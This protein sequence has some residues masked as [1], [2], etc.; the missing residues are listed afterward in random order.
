MGSKKAE[1][2]WKREEGRGLMAEGRRLMWLC[3][4]LF[5]ISCSL[6][7]SCVQQDDTVI[8]KDSRR[9]VEKTVA[10]VAPLNDPI[11]KTRLERTAGWM[12]NNL[13]NAQLHD[14]LCIDLKLEWYD[15]YGN[16]LKELGERLANRNDLM[17]VIGPF[18]SDNV[19]Q[20]APSCQRTHKPLI[21]PTATS[22]TV[23]RRFAITSSGNGQQPF[24]WSLT[25]TDISLSEILVSLY[26]NRLSMQGGTMFEGESDGALFAPADNYG[27]TFVEW[28]PFLTAELGF[29]LSLCEQYENNETLYQKI[30]QYL[31]SLPLLSLEMPQFVVARDIEQIYQIARIR[32]ELWDMD[33]DDPAQDKRDGALVRVFWAPVFYACSNITDEAIAALGPRCQALTSG[34][35]GFSPY[36]DP[37]TGFEISYE[38]RFGTKPT[39][40]ECKFY[41]ALLL[42]GFA[43]NYMEH[44]PKSQTP[45][46][47]SQFNDA[48][49]K[50]CTTDNIL[51]GHAWNETGMEL[52]LAALERGEL[53]GFK[54][55]SGP[56]QFDSECYTAALNTTYVNWS[57]ADGRLYHQSY[58][59]TQGNAQTSK[60]LA[61]WNYLMKDAE[62]RFDTDY[63]K[64]IVTIPYPEL[65]DQYAV[66][67][68]GS[69][70]WDNY[71][72]EA[73][74]LNIYQMLKGNGYDDDH[75]ILITADDCANAP[76]NTDKGAV[77]TDPGGK[78]LHEGAVIDYRNTDLMPQDICN[79]LRGNKTDR[80]PIVLPSDAGQNILFFWSGHGRSKAI[81]GV[82]EMAWRDLSSGKGMTDNLLRETLRSMADNKQFRQV[83]VC[84]EPCYSANMGEALKGMQGV[85]A[86][87]AAGAY[88]QSFA[89][90][91]SNEL[92]VW[93]CDRFS[94]NLVSCA[95]ENPD[96]TYRDL[97]LHCAQHT[98]GSHVGIY[99]YENFGNL[100]TM[101][102]KE[103]FVKKK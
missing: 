89:D 62:K 24:L 71:R 102:P 76:E 12:L 75:I 80:T 98:L 64:S 23:I 2:R 5:A 16:D 45:N 33:P 95:K 1:G 10:V 13:H 100:Y 63:S 11:M 14:T 34:Y 84:L 35:Q 66:L 15:E 56:V 32:S 51:S 91:W 99:N 67:V 77:R 65:T 50:I 38:T 31:S 4:V 18:D 72:H 44:H 30:R 101:S 94:R 9:W 85:L 81:N 93:M 36:A 88:E 49:I 37:M 90:S 47:N 7:T 17:A 86:I 25:E 70:G 73:D 21:L 52:Y 28:A 8:Y 61:S 48:V 59:S 82:N 29:N 6:F 20:L 60:T 68:Q 83:L 22:E 57:I 3:T 43:G 54:G 69:N 40:A 79:I 55:A 46:T 27:Q 26:A 87:C 58:Y 92:H 41:D 78:N 42:S 103:F 19:E 74:V 96:G 97:Y 53:L 39:F